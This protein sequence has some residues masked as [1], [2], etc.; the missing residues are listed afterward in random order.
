M[1]R[2]GWVFG[3]AFLVMAL[4]ACFGGSSLVWLLTTNGPV[5]DFRGPPIGFFLSRVFSGLIFVVGVLG[6]LFLLRTVR[7]TL[8]PMNDLMDAAM[9][10]ERGDFSARVRVRGPRD[11][12]ALITSFNAMTERL[13]ANEQSR[14]NLLA[15]V[16]HELRTP[17]TVIQGNLE[18][19]LDGIYPRDDAHLAPILEE[20]KVMARLIEDLRTL[21]LAEAGTLQLQR[22]SVDLSALAKDV[23]TSFRSQADG[24]TIALVVDASNP[25]MADVDPQRM[26]E[27]MSNL[28]S[29][30]LRY[31]D[32]GAITVRV[33]RDGANAGFEVR[34]TGRGIA[35]D[36]QPHIF[37]RFYKGRDSSGT[38]L[39]L[40]IAKQLVQ[41]HGGEINVESVVGA[42]TRMFVT[43]P[44]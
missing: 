5:D 44:V 39:G 31:T 34:D 38:G 15:D 2:W 10:V 19:V 9:R 27:V 4:L 11:V 26:R 41:A 17:L 20:T 7:L 6:F 37:D 14:R 29:N 28:I 30:A 33:W 25:V 3:L 23:V 8:R 21:S 35:P 32:T 43:M 40:A 13:Q 12:R 16:T 24:K 42:G 1:R 18:G 36:V 22:E